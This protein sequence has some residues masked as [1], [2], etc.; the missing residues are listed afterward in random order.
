MSESIITLNN[1][2]CFKYSNL[3]FT[4]QFMHYIST[5]VFAHPH[6]CLISLNYGLKQFLCPISF[7]LNTNVIKLFMATVSDLTSKITRLAPNGTNPGL[8]KISFQQKTD[9]IKS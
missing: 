7:W 8:F 6:K 4:H 9:L 3:I 2:A 1:H 5:D